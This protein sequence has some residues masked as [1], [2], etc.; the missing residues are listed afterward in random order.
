MAVVVVGRAHPIL[1][2]VLYAQSNIAAG[3]LLLCE[4]PVMTMTPFRELGGEERRAVLGAA[5]ELGVASLDL[6]C[7]A[8][9]FAASTPEL[10]ARL[11]STFC[12][13]EAI[14]PGMREVALRDVDAAVRWATAHL[15]GC[16]AVPVD[17]LCQ[18]LICFKLN[19]HHT[20]H[21]GDR[22]CGAMYAS[23]SRF[24]HAC[25]SA[26]CAFEHDAQDRLVHRAV[27]QIVA[28][29]MLTTNYLGPW[30]YGSTRARRA[31]LLS[32][33]CFDCGCSECARE[34]DAMR[35]IPCR[36]CGP[37]RGVDGLLVETTDDAS[38]A[39]GLEGMASPSPAQGGGEV[40]TCACCG[41]TRSAVEMDVALTPPHD[42]PLVSPLS[43]AAAA[44]GSSLLEWE[45]RV[46]V[47][48]HN[49][50]LHVDAATDGTHP[51]LL[52]LPAILVAVRRLLGRSHWA[53][54]FLSAIQLEAALALTA[55]LEDQPDADLLAV[56]RAQLGLNVCSLDDFLAR[57]V[58]TA[59]GLRAW[60]LVRA[61]LAATPLFE[62]V[63]ELAD[64]ALR[65]SALPASATAGRERRVVLEL[66][67][68]LA[69]DD[70]E[71][72]VR[73]H[74]AESQESIEL[75]ERAEALALSLVQST[76]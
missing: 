43:G 61:P 64:L 29:Q 73:Q 72:R 56:A 6:I 67:L 20:P 59:I 2:N 9:A 55:R 49:L 8:H 27:R 25:L 39:A 22:R 38:I 65:V 1:G 12:G 15:R 50:Q 42:W 63:L 30:E 16:A 31:L 57:C 62:G 37:P 26:N 71:R 7:T 4:E 18:A 11:L 66:V 28:G 76:S 5:A 46:E 40:W 3:T 44:A 51:T 17:E 33:K 52:R 58:R 24:T 14:P 60:Q 41:D 74:G 36:A 54:A 70:V 45:R 47:A 21:L 19:A 48:A 75:A 32:S 13:I 53:Y 34:P 10:R 35:A 23:G 69:H 68:R